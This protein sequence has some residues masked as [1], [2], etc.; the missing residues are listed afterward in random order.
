[1]S[2]AAPTGQDLPLTGQ[3]SLDSRE[4]LDEL[5]TSFYAS[6]LSDDLLGPVFGAA[7][8]DLVTHLPR[9]GDFWQRTLLSSGRYDGQPMAVHA[10]LH[11][12]VPLT[13]EMFD[14][15]LA[16]WTA[17]VDA[18]YAGPTAVRAKVTAHRVA[19][20]MQRQLRG[21]P[22]PPAPGLQLVA[23]PTSAA[24]TDLQGQG[25]RSW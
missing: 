23:P 5:L 7:H 14:R 10:R 25:E 21:D 22:E 20:A 11:A 8:L 12:R 4:A 2:P 15:W 13:P 18:A 3:R 1:M 16:L 19:A 24:R 17:A 6:A 9:I